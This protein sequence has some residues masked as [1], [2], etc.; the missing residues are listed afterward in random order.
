MKKKSRGNDRIK[1]FYDRIDPNKYTILAQFQLLLK[2]EP[3]VSD[4]VDFLAVQNARLMAL[5]TEPLSEDMASQILEFA[6]YFF[7][8]YDDLTYEAR[9]DN[10]PN[11]AYILRLAASIMD[12]IT[13]QKEQKLIE[14][15]T[16]AERHEAETL[17]D[18]IMDIRKNKTITC[19]TGG[20]FSYKFIIPATMR[21]D[22][23]QECREDFFS[24]CA[25]MIKAGGSMIVRTEDKHRKR[26]I[27]GIRVLDF[28]HI[29]SPISK[30]ELFDAHTLA[31]DG[32]RLSPEEGLVY[33]EIVRNKI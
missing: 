7:E 9:M 25:L 28:L 8:Y 3:T 11:D 21:K 17:L 24:L 30:E 2:E 15:L 20:D 16:E 5:S 13:K 22:E 32:N 31:P 19:V 4:I 14:S 18:T 23:L 29:W 1:N 12:E 6:D 27:F 33:T 10:W 26:E